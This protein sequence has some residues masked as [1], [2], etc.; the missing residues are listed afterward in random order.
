M[1][2][3]SK[4]ERQYPPCAQYYSQEEFDYESFLSNTVPSGKL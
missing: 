1:T 3:N 4:A 2:D